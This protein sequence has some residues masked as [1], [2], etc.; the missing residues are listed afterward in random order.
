MAPPTPTARSAPS[1]VTNPKYDQ[2][3]VVTITFSLNPSLDIWEITV[4]PP[5]IDGGDGIETNTQFNV[6]YETMRARKLVKNEGAKT[7]VQ[8][9]SG[10]FM[11][12]LAM[13]NKEQT[14]TVTYPDGTTICF[15]GFLKSAK[16]S[17]F[18]Q[19][20]KP[21]VDIET[22]CTNWDP[23]GHV[24]AGPVFTQGSGTGF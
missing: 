23:A 3:F 22:V 24:E 14:I 8:I 9:N 11:A 15:F 18:Q 7:K 17:E 6:R 16:H 2:G 1:N 13:T 19:G 4:T 5:G 12:L 10:S 20:E 21:T